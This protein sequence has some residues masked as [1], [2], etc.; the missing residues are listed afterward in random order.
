MFLFSS[1]SLN[2]LYF[3]P[4]NG[5]KQRV[6]NINANEGIKLNFVERTKTRLNPLNNKLDDIHNTKMLCAI[7]HRQ[8]RLAVVFPLF[9]SFPSNRL[10]HVRRFER[11]CLPLFRFRRKLFLK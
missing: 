3:C 4:A 6:T 7:R 2:V 9:P 5:A 10:E 1:L 8:T 11:H